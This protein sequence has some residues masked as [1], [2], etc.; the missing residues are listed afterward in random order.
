MLT[1]WLVPWMVGWGLFGFS[2][3]LQTS[4]PFMLLPLPLACLTEGWGA[5]I[6]HITT[7]RLY[8]AGSALAIGIPSALT[9]TEPG[10]KESFQQTP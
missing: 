6:Q 4:N 7:E 2:T 1:K 5:F 10:V 8:V 9:P 3:S